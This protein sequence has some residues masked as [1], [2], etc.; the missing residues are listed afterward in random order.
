MAADGSWCFA[1]YRLEVHNA[2]LWCGT[3]A[4][5]LKAKAF[6]V[7][8]YLVAHA[9][10]LVTK[11][12]LFAA[13]WPD[14]EVSEGVLTNCVG[15]L[16]KALGDT[17][18]TPRFIATVR[19]RGYRFIAPVTRGGPAAAPAAPAAVAIPTAPAAP[20]L[21]VGRE[22]E[23]HA[24]RHWLAQA[25]QGR[26]Q[27]VFVTGEA[28]MGKTTVVDALLATTAPTAP[29]GV[30]W[31]QCLAQYG[32]GEAYLP[33][34]DALGRLCRTPGH[35]HLIALLGQHAPT[36]LAQ[37]PGLLSPAA[38]ADVQRRVQ[39][40]TRE[41]MLREL[42]EALEVVTAAQPLVLVL[43]D[44]Q[45]SDHATLDLLAWLARRREPARLLLVGTYRPVEVIVR[46]HPLQAVHQDLRLHGQ[47]A[48]LPLEGLAE[49]AVAA[50]LAARFPGSAVAT[51]LG[52]VL[53]RRT[54]GHPLF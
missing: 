35:E 50:Y 27:V 52:G 13:I 12:D 14:L 29:L 31:G 15:E 54:D 5:H 43:E 30:A 2:Q 19:G 26:R 3:Q 28:G 6:D 8:C 38:L 25:L 7:L 49:T 18:Q 1:P 51:A 44:L 9:G 33:V 37:M 45:W 21:L 24:L 39:G 17:T 53:A 47:C 32:A 16:R 42:A 10:Q 48:D 36:W 4:L 20:P 46:A 40:A 11:D 23:L 22:T 34:L 41:R